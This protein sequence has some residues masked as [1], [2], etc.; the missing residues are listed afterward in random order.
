MSNKFK[1]REL[2]VAYLNTLYW[3]TGLCLVVN[4]HV[5]WNI[6]SDCFIS[7]CSKLFKKLAPGYL[8]LTVTV[9]ALRS[10][11]VFNLRNYGK[12]SKLHKSQSQALILLLAL[13]LGQYN[14]KWRLLE[15]YRTPVQNWLVMI[16]GCHL[17]SLVNLFK[18]AWPDAM[19]SQIGLHWPL[20]ISSWGIESDL[21]IAYCSRSSFTS[22]YK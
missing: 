3:N 5:T 4:S 18:N 14:L 15:G 2:R 21:A 1:S 10:K 9:H 22:C 13:L 8:V 20:K 6:Q 19:N 12:Y 16:P 17:N 11:S 7:A